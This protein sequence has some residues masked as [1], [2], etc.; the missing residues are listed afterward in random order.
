MADDDLEDNAVRTELLLLSGL[1]CDET[2]WSRLIPD[3][4][5]IIPVRAVD[6]RGFDSIGAMADHVLETAPA[7][8]A[9]AGHSMGARVALEIH[10]RAPDRIDRLA[11]LDTGTHPAKPGEAESRQKLVDLAHAQGMAALADRWLPPMLAPANRAQASMVEP[12]RD[13]V[14]RMSPDIYEAQVKALLNRPDAAAGL[15]QIRCPTLV[16]VGEHDEWS[17]LGQHQLIAEHIDG[18]T[19]VV[20]PDSGHMAPFEASREVAAA[21][22]AWLGH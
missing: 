19:L 11:L 6:F 14:L 3:L 8:F 15:G 16:G 18:A 1:L 12:L 7:T 4:T 13:M 9:L 2:V 21:L 22:R 17:P 10:R 20:F 5:D